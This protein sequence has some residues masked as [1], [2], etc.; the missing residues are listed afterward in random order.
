[1]LALLCDKNP[2]SFIAPGKSRLKSFVPEEI[3]RLASS[4]SDL[5]V[6][7]DY[8]LWVIMVRSRPPREGG[9]HKETKGSWVT[10]SYGNCRWAV[11][12]WR[13]WGRVIGELRR[14]VFSLFGDGEGLLSKLYATFALKV[15]TEGAGSS[16]LYFT[17]LTEKADPLLRRWPLR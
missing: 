2:S 7:S 15:L 10:Y 3:N 6:E 8:R 13:G 12:R 4:N 9:N 17:A 14:R 5:C 11:C 16:Q 1:M